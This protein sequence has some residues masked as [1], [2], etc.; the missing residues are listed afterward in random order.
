MKTLV[1][2]YVE[3]L[4]DALR[5]AA[6]FPALVEPSPVRAHTHAQAQVITVQVGAERVTDSATPRVTRMR[7]IHLLVHTAGDDGLGLSERVFSAA[8]PVLMHFTGPGLVQV[9]ELR[10]D[11]PRYVN[12]DL[13]RQ[14]I[15]KRYLFTYQTAED[16]LSA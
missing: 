8:H 3:G 6:G 2:L 7:E 13:L 14:A 1:Q 16:S 9:E 11:E 15:T 4:H 10:T 5:S 12:G